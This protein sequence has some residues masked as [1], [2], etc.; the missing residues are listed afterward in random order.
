MNRLGW[1]V[2]QQAGIKRYFAFASFFTL[3]GV[4]LSVVLIAMGNKG[5]WVLLAIVVIA[6]GGGYLFLNSTRKSQP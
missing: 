1:T 6:W 3:L 4:I 5:G 2:E